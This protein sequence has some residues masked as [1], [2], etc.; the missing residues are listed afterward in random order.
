MTLQEQLKEYQEIKDL[1]LQGLKDN[2]KTG[3]LLGYTTNGTKV[4]YEGVTKTN[5]LLREYNS[6][7]STANANISLA[8]KRGY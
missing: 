5:E 6:L 1:I 8:N 3:S 4:T 2:L 7:I